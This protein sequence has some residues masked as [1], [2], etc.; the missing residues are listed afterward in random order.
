MSQYI[1]PGAGTGNAAG[2]THDFQVTDDGGRAL[3]VACDE[4]SIRAYD[5]QK[6]RC[7]KKGKRIRHR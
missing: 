7:I 6:S 2:S 4:Q 3:F 1:F 5:L